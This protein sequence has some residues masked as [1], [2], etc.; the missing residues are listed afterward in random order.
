ME[1]TYKVIALSV[2]GLNNKIFNSGETV[3]ADNFP[4]G[5]AEDLVKQGFLQEVKPPEDKKK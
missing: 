3:T 4:R 5:N 2:G 1:K